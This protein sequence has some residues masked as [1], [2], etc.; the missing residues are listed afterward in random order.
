MDQAVEVANRKAPEHLELQ[1]NEPEA[2]TR[3]LKNYGSTVR[4]GLSAEVLGDYSSGINHVLPTG[5]AARFSGGLGSRISSRSRPFCAPR[6]GM[7]R[8]APPPPQSLS[9]GL[10]CPSQAG[11][12]PRAAKTIGEK[13]ELNGFGGFLPPAHDLIQY[14]GQKPAERKSAL[15]RECRDGP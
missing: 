10:E 12:S 1:V 15:R 3:K 7:S 8:T 9:E 5:G 11:R 4:R 6:G 2:M 13:R 14:L